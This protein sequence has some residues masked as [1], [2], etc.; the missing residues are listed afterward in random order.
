MATLGLIV[1]LTFL[2]VAV[3]RHPEH[4]A[5]LTT[6]P[7][8]GELDA[9]IQRASPDVRHGAFTAFA[10]FLS[11]LGGGWVTTPL[12]IAITLW[13]LVGR[14]YLAFAVFALAWAGSE[15]IMTWLKIFY[16]RGRPPDPLVDTHSYSFPSGHATAGAALAIALVLVFFDPG[17]RRQLWEATAAGFAFV[18]ALS[19]VYLSAHWFSDVVTGV[20]LGCAIA[21]GAGAVV[22]EVA[23][24]LARRGVIPALETPPGDP[25]DPRLG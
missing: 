13:L 23:N 22:T 2:L 8:V 9:S 21:I 11:V 10:M 6:L 20:I 17:P 5:P 3:G 15:G 24:V 12:R 7:F 25:L 16:H 18:M 4:L 1:A 19:R 14:R